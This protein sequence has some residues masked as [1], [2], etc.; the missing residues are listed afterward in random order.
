MKLIVLL[1]MIS[2]VC[3]GQDCTEIKKETDRFTNAVKYSFSETMIVGIGEDMLGIDISK[4]GSA[5]YLLVVSPNLGCVDGNSAVHFLYDDGTSMRA[6]NSSE[7]NCD[8][9]FLISLKGIYLGEQSIK[10]I[11]TKKIKA[12]KAQA[13]SSSVEVDLDDDDSARLLAALQCFSKIK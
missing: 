7:F 9:A 5:K 10:N 4:S 2:S 13:M 12:I 6:V 8:G 1:L 11:F 3:F